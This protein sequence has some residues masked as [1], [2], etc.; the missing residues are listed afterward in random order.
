MSTNYTSRL[1]KLSPAKR[2]LLVEALRADEEWRSAFKKIPPRAV[3]SPVVLSFAQQRLWFIDQLDP[4]NP[5]YNCPAAV[6]L[7]GAL[8]LNA[9]CAAFDHLVARHES[10]RTTFAAIDGLP[11]QI[12]SPPAPLPLPVL[13]L[14]A[15]PPAQHR[16]EVERIAAAEAQTRFDLASGPLLRVQLLRLAPQEHVLLLTLHHIIGDAWSVGVLVRE[17]AELYESYRSGREPVLEELPIQYGDFAVWQREWLQGAELERQMSY[18]REQLEGMRAKT[19]AGGKGEAGSEGGAASEIKLTRELTQE[20]RELSRRQGVTL[21]MLLLAAFKVLLYRYSGER[22]VVVG[23]G[24]ANRNRV[25][26]EGLIGFFVNMLVLRTQVRREWSFAEMLKRVEEVCVGAYAHQDV[27]FEKLVEELQPERNLSHTPLFQVMMLLQNASIEEFQ[28]EGLKLDW[29]A[30]PTQAAKFD[31][32]LDLKEEQGILGGRIEYN[33]DLFDAPTIRRMT[34]QFEYLLEQVTKNPEQKV[35]DLTL[36]REEEAHQILSMWNKTDVLGDEVCIHEQFEIQ[37][38]LTPD[39]VAVIS[40]EEELTY[41]ELNSRANRLAHYLRRRGVSPEVRVGICL[42]RSVK[43]V[44]SLLAVFKAGGA[45]VPLDPNYPA[46]RLAFVQQDAQV[47]LLVTDESLST[48]L[49]RSKVDVVILDREWP[50]IAAEKNENPASVVNAGNIAYVIYTSGSTGKPKGVMALHRGAMNRFRWMWKTY[51]FAAHEICCQKTS[52]GFVDSVW[53]IF[54][55]LLQGIPSVIIPDDVVKNP[56]ALNRYLAAHR[57]TRIVLVP[58]LLRALLDDFEGFNHPL[59][60]L[61][62]WISSGEALPLELSERFREVMPGR[63]L[64]NLYGSSEASADSTYFEAGECESAGSVLIGRPIDNTQIYVLDEYMQ[65][66]PVGLPGELYIGGD[67]L[68]RGYLSQPLLTAEKFIPNPFSE[69]PGRRLYKTGDLA[70]WTEDGYIEYVGRIDQQV[71]IRGIRI[72]LGEVEAVLSRHP[73]VKQAVVITLEEVP[74]EKRLVAYIVPNEGQSPGVSQL[75]SFIREEL[76]DYMIPS[77]FVSLETLPLTLSGKVNRLALPRPL[78]VRPQLDVVYTPPRTAVEKELAGI[79]TELLRTEQ[80]GV[81]DNFFDLGGH[82]LLATQLLSRVRMHFHVEAALQDF[83]KRP[84]IMNLAEVIEE[85]V[86]A[87]ANPAS[88]S[89]LLDLLESLDEENL[90]STLVHNVLPMAEA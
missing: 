23:T 7:S 13:D 76:P 55:P 25:E 89:K 69:V 78:E 24:I 72:E 84:T 29:F 19:R 12:I 16:R 52:L 18:W 45:Y 85:D 61:R 74:G 26:T 8:D 20:L 67:G 79:W 56:Q 57:I 53:E 59:P 77:A 5:A 63:L 80:I 34:G 58:S 82:S 31:L 88:M 40:E 46:E 73:D 17:L 21:F 37:A 3:K 70:R 22:E 86:I 83:F 48:L 41:R 60:R 27:P 30:V 62:F 68:A 42:K 51:P 33:V 43:A 38:E 47:S 54:G 50:A 71:K 87:R 1:E 65:P 15:H 32:T 49:T 6:S 66:K 44:V 11:H 14:Q 2:A 4:G 81:D 35:L 28:L 90:P 75:R 64:L 9:L 10:L 39:A 36:L